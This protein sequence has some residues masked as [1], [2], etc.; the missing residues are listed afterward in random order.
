MKFFAISDIHSFYD[1]MIDALNKAGF[2]KNNPEHTLIV[3]GDAFDRGTQAEE[4]LEYLNSLERVVLVKGNHDDILMELL[5]RRF[6][7]SSDD[8]NGTT[9][10]VYQLGYEKG[11]VKFADFCDKAY[12]QFKPLY[13]KMVDYYETGNYI[14]VHSWI[15][16]FST[17]YGYASFIDDWRNASED[18]WMNARWGNPYELAEKGLKPDK[19]I[20]FGH[21]HTSWARAYFEGKDE[22]GS[23]ADF[24]TYY[25][26][27]Y[28]GLDAM[29]AHTGKVNVLVV[30]DNMI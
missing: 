10:T 11:T 19:T 29:T 27:G 1:P 23:E 6:P 24:S 15:P 8:H 4:I 9:G 25:G 7:Y 28:I 20:V 13:D 12:K 21:W 18:L 16:C 30:E 22:F 2:E 17:G 3:C 5:E 14:F 26:N